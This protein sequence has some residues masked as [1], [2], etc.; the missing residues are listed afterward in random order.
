MAESPGMS[1]LIRTPWRVG[2]LVTA[3]LLALVSCSSGGGSRIPVAQM[4]GA[5]SS[6]TPSTLLGK[7]AY[8]H[9]DG[10]YF[11]V[12]TYHAPARATTD[13]V[14]A[15]ADRHP[16]I[17]EYFQRW[18]QEFD[19]A[20][21]KSSYDQGAIPLLTWEPQAAS[22][23]AN[24][25][26]YS[27]QKI[28]SG[29][30]D[31]YIVRFAE[32]VRT[33]QR[34]VIL[35]F[36]HEMNG[37]WYPWSEKNSGNRPGDYVKAWRHVHDLFSAVGATNVIWLWSPNVLRGAPGVDLASLY[38]GDQY[39]DWM[40]VDAYGFGEK[41]ASEVL[42]STARI[43]YRISD[44]PLLISETGAEPGAEQAGWTASLFRWIKQ[45]PRTIGFVWFQHSEDEGGLH[46]YRFDINPATKSAFRHGLD[47]LELRDWPVPT[48]AATPSSSATPL[49]SAAP[50]EGR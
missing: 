16:T 23:D 42:D 47:S 4:P 49:T 17:L 9:P 41:T 50:A 34:T 29:D 38:P 20:A 37:D 44:K 1:T 14:T 31:S 8:L 32:A 25:P 7:S 11:G 30:F 15:A 6:A 48:V 33:Q 10:V 19:P 13:A 18:D 3:L 27:L 28:A 21:V 43:L 36:A 12:S 5:S 40:G 35:R 22:K 45:N 26:A 39:V 24:Q 46:D 2:V